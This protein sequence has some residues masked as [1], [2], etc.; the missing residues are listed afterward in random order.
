M[1]LGLSVFVW[2]VKWLTSQSPFCRSSWCFL[3]KPS[4][5][6]IYCGCSWIWLSKWYNCIYSYSRNTSRHIEDL[7]SRT[8]SNMLSHEAQQCLRCLNRWQSSDALDSLLIAYVRL[9]RWWEQFMDEKT[10]TWLVCHWISQ[11]QV[12]FPRQNP[13]WKSNYKGWQKLYQLGHQISSILFLMSLHYAIK[14]SFR[15]KIV[16]ILPSLDCYLWRHTKE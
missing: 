12:D 8:V 2:S 16:L 4:L 5:V 15:P 11:R 14:V 3:F 1:P 10:E 7:E 13:G 6:V 9:L